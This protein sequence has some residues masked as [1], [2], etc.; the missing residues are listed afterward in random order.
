MVKNYVIDTNVMIHDPYFMYQFE[1]N[2][3]IIPLVTLEELD[4]LKKAE[5]VVGYHARKVL[6]ELASIREEGDLLRGIPLPSGGSIRVETN[7]VDVMNLPTDMDPKK[8]DNRILSV[9]KGIAEREKEKP[10]ILV[11]KDMCM[12]VKADALGIKVEDYETD[13]ISTDDLYQGYQEMYLPSKLIDEMYQGG[14]SVEE[15]P[16]ERGDLYPNQFIHIKSHDQM[17]HESIGKVQNGKVVPLEYTGEYT[18]G[19][20]P[21]NMEQ[22]MAMELLHDPKVSFL[23]IIGG[24]GSGKT[25]L[26]IAYA[27]QSVLENNRFR[28]II[29]VRP[30]VPAGHDIGYLP[31]EEKEKLK[32]WM[33]AFYDAIDNLFDAKQKE[34]KQER[35]RKDFHGGKPTFNVDHFIQTYME[36]GI[37][38]MKTFN[39]MRG[40]TLSN[41]LV[42][43]DEAQETTPHLAKLMLTRAGEGTKF[44][45]LGDPSDNQI[46]NVLVDS[47]SNGLVYTVDRMKRFEITG[48]ITLNQVERSPLAKIA[49]MGM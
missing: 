23:S 12:T 49:E 15:L 10:T 31:G 20:K 32:P 11:T 41:A 1:E 36:A 13:K 24:A 17:G 21:L 18:W 35:W 7:Y 16:E 37:I 39:Y 9:V 26:S 28:K 46:D 27:L 42:I 48:H 43:V 25:I 19:L 40:R 44:L 45:F 8:N 38:E 5:G 33:Q 30:V 4:G 29:I 47:K 2:E 6:N 14:I 3:I 22:T 34:E